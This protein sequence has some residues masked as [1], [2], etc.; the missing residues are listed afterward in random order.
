[1]ASASAAQ[2]VRAASTGGMGG[3]ALDPGS[4][5]RG[6]SGSSFLAEY[7]EQVEAQDAG[8]VEVVR[9]RFMNDDQYVG[10]WKN[11][12]PSGSGRYVWADG[13]SYEGEWLHGLKHGRGRYAWGSG[14]TY[15]GEWM[16]G[17]MQGVG[18]HTSPDGTRYEGS[19]VKDVKHGL[20]RKDYPNGDT[21]EGL[22]R[23]GMSDGPGRYQ[24]A[25]GSEYSGEW[26]AGE[27]SGHGTFVWANGDRYD[28]EWRDS[29]EHGHGIFTW[30]DTSVYDGEWRDG[31]KHGRGIFYPAGVGPN[32][33][34]RSKDANR[35]KRLAKGRSYSA[36]VVVS[37]QLRELP[38]NLP[39]RR[40][41]KGKRML[42]TSLSGNERLGETVYKGHRS[43]ELMVNLQLGIRHSVGRLAARG[44][45]SEVV[46]SDFRAKVKV[47]FPRTGGPTTPPHSS[48]DFKWKDYCPAVFQELRA[49]FGV[50]T[51]DYMLSVCGDKALSQMGSPGKSGSV[52]FISDD[53][54]FIIKTMRK[55]EC[56]LLMEM[57]P[58][59]H[60]HVRKYPQTLLTRFLGMYR[61]KPSGG[62]NVRFVVMG[63]LFC[64]DLRIHRR[65][66]L[67]GSTQGRLTAPDKQLKSTTILKDL[68]L[69][70]VFKMEATW[71]EKLMRQ[72]VHDCHLLERCRVM[73]YSLLLGIASS[74]ERVLEVDHRRDLGVDPR[75]VDPAPRALP[76]HEL[77]K[78]VT[79]RPQRS[80][81][82]RPLP[83]ADGGTDALAHAFGHGRVELGVNMAAVAVPPDHRTQRNRRRRVLGSGAVSSF[84]DTEAGVDEGDEEGDEDNDPA[85][86]DCVL[87]FGVIDFLRAA[88][89][90]EA[91][92]TRERGPSSCLPRDALADACG[93]RACSL[94][95][96]VPCAQTEEYNTQKQAENVFKSIIHDGR[97]ISAVDPVRY[98]RRFQE[99]MRSK[100][101]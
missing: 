47:S 55:H 90:R 12:K 69:P 23:N 17:C 78:V 64:T 92:A 40:R 65:Y 74:L 6:D 21:F 30:A 2:P 84:S 33:A 52:F 27:M 76:R 11:G 86:R 71:R 3:A 51:G 26:H 72:M 39:R 59:Y 100:F 89:S 41:K 25:D 7:R 99:F 68:D 36:G 19:W 50:D 93:P 63:N 43:Y 20:G 49:L 95:A 42:Y 15:D 10:G 66:D 54:R 73:D 79:A 29:H 97:T 8:A 98:S 88:P 32:K 18:T 38:R 70:V 14:A 77:V 61:V 4:P 31:V 16:D 24:W 1:M 58:R 35:A 82:L 101:V 85:V 37:E 94:A 13:S 96:R 56:K 44:A 75:R 34:Q 67:K 83:G 57:L 81:T 62:R 53:D 60:A 22:W 91:R 80:H 5:A 9:K 46:G 28:G 87:Y 45:P 48:G